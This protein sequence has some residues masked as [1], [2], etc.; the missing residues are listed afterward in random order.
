MVHTHLL[1]AMVV[2]QRV[3]AHLWMNAFAMEYQIPVSLRSFYTNSFVVRFQNL[4]WKNVHTFFYLQDGDIIN[5]DVT[6]YLNVSCSFFWEGVRCLFCFFVEWTSHRISFTMYFAWFH[7]YVLCL[8]CLCPLLCCWSGWRLG[9]ICVTTYCYTV[10]LK[11]VPVS[12]FLRILIH[13][14]ERAA[15][16]SVV[17]FPLFVLQLHLLRCVKFRL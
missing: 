11:L 17:C 12:I 2:F 6:V 5:I 7:Y 14:A 13:L 10:F 1:L 3:F 8:Q 4:A 15:L 16:R 9:I